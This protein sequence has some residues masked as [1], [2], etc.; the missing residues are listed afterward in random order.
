MSILGDIT[1]YGKDALQGTAAAEAPLPGNPYFDKA[2]TAEVNDARK[3][4]NSTGQVGKDIT[5]GIAAFDAPIPGNPAFDKV[6]GIDN[7]PGVK[8]LYTDVYGIPHDVK[9]WLDSLFSSGTSTAA[10]PPAGTTTTTP[11]TPDFEQQLGSD[12]TQ[13]LAPNTAQA[14]SMLSGYNQDMKA[15]SGN[16]PASIQKLMTSGN[17]GGL[18]S[19]EVSADTSMSQN[20][21]EMSQI[22]ALLG[23]MQNRALYNSL[24]LTD[25]Y[26][27]S[28]NTGIQ[29]LMNSNVLGGLADV[30]GLQNGGTVTAKPIAPTTATAASGYPTTGLPSPQLP[31]S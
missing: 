31:N 24:P 29:A 10:T 21:P 20:A 2:V 13:Q 18:L 14:N 22:Q 15:F 1:R 26:G 17:I 12:I 27:N 5:T 11:T 9:G 8:S 28:N 7:I 4:Y 16:Q 19:N 6:T 25:V 23:Q 30:E 3:V